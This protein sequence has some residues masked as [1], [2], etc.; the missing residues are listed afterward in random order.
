MESYMKIWYERRSNERFR[1][2][3]IRKPSEHDYARLIHSSSFRRLQTKTQV[4]GLGESD[5]YRTRLTHSLEVAQIGTGILKLLKDSYKTDQNK[6]S[7]LPDSILMS[8]ICLAHD[9]GHP[10]F[11]HGGEIALNICMR[12]AGGFEG[13]G[14]TL[15]ILSKLEKYTNG[16][17]INP[18]RRLLLGVLKYP[19]YYSKANLNNTYDNISN[20]KWLSKA[21][22]QKPPK[23]Y[24]DDEKDV[25]Q[26]I[27][28]PLQNTERTVFEGY[29]QDNKSLYHGLDTSIMELADDISFSLHD[30]EDAI[31]LKMITKQDW[32]QHNTDRHIKL[33]DECKLDFQNLTKK[34]FSNESYERKEAIGTL[35]HNFIIN[36]HLK[37]LSDPN[38]ISPIFKL[39]A[40]MQQ[41]Q[42]ILREH[43]FDLVYKK[44][45]KNTNV[46]LLELKGQKIVIELFD[47]LSSDPERL[48]PQTIIHKYKNA[49]TETKQKRVICDYIAGMT[50]IYATKLYEKIYSPKIGS[51]FD[52]L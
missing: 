25:V 46:Q 40:Y 48:L 31:S 24:L 8:A 47:A 11:G 22:N 18:T 5:F 26:W 2:S 33:F 30:L 6:V 38:I 4:I 39:Q 9:I 32:E 16:Y 51:I 3:D 49:A 45:I 35:V 41:N 43:I 10:P 1:D 34:L 23:C 36:I 37:E 14:Q 29:Q 20:P 13:N 28:E 27:L 42:N 15:R 44:V 7:A 12:D 21:K 17:G 19:I 50:D 52:H